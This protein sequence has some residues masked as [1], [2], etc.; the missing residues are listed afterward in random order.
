MIRVVSIISVEQ[1]IELLRRGG[2]LDE[3]VPCCAV[4]VE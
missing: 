1:S 2:E 4:P 3:L